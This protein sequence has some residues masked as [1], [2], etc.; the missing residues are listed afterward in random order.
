[1]GRDIKL[2]NGNVASRIL[3]I[4]IHDLDAEDKAIIENEIG[5]VLRAIEFIYKEAGVNRPLKSTDSKT[6]NQNKTDYRNQVNKTANAVKEI[7]LGLKNAGKINHVVIKSQHQQGS[8]DETGNRS[9][10]VLPFVNMSSDPEQEYFSDGMAEEIINSLVHLKDLKVAG[11]TSSFQFKGKNPDLR[12][13]GE[14]LGVKTV[15]EGSIR[16]Q[17]NLLRITAQLINVEDGFHLWS[18]R[19]DRTLDDIFAIQD[20]I[21]LAITEKLQITLMGKDREKIT[22]SYTE[23]PE[24][25][26]FYLKGRFYLNKRLLRESL[27]QFEKAVAIDPRYARA[28]AGVADASII[29]SNYGFFPPIEIMPKAKLAAEK[30][31]E[32]DDSL[33]EP[34]CS[35]ALYYASFEWNWNEAK[36]NFKR[37]IE[38]NPAYSQAYIWYG[39]YYLTWIEGNYREGE[40]LLNIAIKLEPLSAIGYLSMFAIQCNTGKPE[41]AFQMA[42]E[43]FALDQDSYVSQ[44]VMGLAFAGRKE[45]GKATECLEKASGMSK[46]SALSLADLIYLYMQRG[47]VDKAQEVK[48]ELEMNMK[49]RKYTSPFMMGYAYSNLGNFDEAFNW[50]EKAYENHDG[51]LFMMRN[52]PW[53]PDKLKTDERFISLMKRLKVPNF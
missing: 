3:P 18:E 30:A 32:L 38:L 31:I 47:M 29:L 42:K 21:A 39:Q 33:C 11:R 37:S 24:A 26:F 35:L 52:Y 40:K 53:L 5:G 15:L 2:S 23:N 20:E 19:Y 1:M 12:E 44:R 10:A 51:F 25:Y 7:I 49:V 17:G 36:K 43:G 14:R 27:E 22:K 8:R 50:F 46:R 16:K 34:Y 13:V 6:D 28:Y 41:E 9:I 4:K 48:G 45:F